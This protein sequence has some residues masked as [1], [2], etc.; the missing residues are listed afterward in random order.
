MMMYY[1]LSDTFLMLNQQMYLMDIYQHICM[2]QLYYLH[3]DNDHLMSHDITLH[4]ISILLFHPHNQFNSQKIQ[5][6]MMVYI[7]L[8]L[9]MQI[10]QMNM[11]IHKN[12]HLQNNHNLHSQFLKKYLNIQIHKFLVMGHHKFHMDIRYNKLYHFLH[13]YINY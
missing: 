9:E 8:Y 7:F 1:I 5:Q 3:K 6:D 4:I 2:A 12:F 13:I 10:I 11:F